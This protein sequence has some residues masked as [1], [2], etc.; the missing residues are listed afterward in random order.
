[1]ICYLMA[2]LVMHSLVALCA[3]KYKK[4]YSTLIML[5][6]PDQAVVP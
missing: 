5:E 1:M 4:M 6:I 2:I 3:C